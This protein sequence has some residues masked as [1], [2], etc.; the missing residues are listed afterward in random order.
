MNNTFI[1]FNNS[2]LSPINEDF[3]TYTEVDTLGIITINSSHVE[4]NGNMRGTS[5]QYVYK[6]HESKGSYVYEWD[7]CIDSVQ[8]SSAFY[9]ETTL[10]LTNITN[11]WKYIF[12]N[13]GDGIFVITSSLSSSTGFYY[14][15]IDTHAGVN[16]FNTTTQ[17]A[18][19]IDTWYY[20][21]LEKDGLDITLS[22]YSDE[23]RTSLVESISITIGIGDDYT[24]DKVFIASNVG[25]A[26]NYNIHGYTRNLDIGNLGGGALEG[27]IYTKDLLSLV[28]DDVTALITNT[29]IEGSSEI[30]VEFSND[31]VTW[32]NQQKIVGDETIITGYDGFNLEK[33]EY[34]TLYLRF[35]FSRPSTDD[36]V[37]L[38]N[39]KVIY[40]SDIVGGL[41]GVWK[42]YY[43]HTIDIKV[44]VNQWGNL[45]SMWAI[46]GKTIKGNEEAV[47]PAMLTTGNFTIPNDVISGGL[48]IYGEYVGNPSHDIKYEVWNFDTEEWE[49]I[50]E[51]LT[52]VGWMWQNESI[53]LNGR[54][55]QAF[56]ATH[57]DVWVR[58]IHT[59]QGNILHTLEIDYIALIGFF[60]TTELSVNITQIVQQVNE[61]DGEW[62]TYRL[63]NISIITGTNVWG[64]LSSMWYVDGKTIY[65]NEEAETPAMLVHGNFTIPNNLISASLHVFGEY[66][67]NP[68]HDI[69]YQV[70]NFDLTEWEALGDPL[71]SG[72]GMHW[73]NRSISLDGQYRQEYNSTHDNVWIRLIHTNQGV[74]THSLEVDYVALHGLLPANRQ[75]WLGGL[76]ILVPVLIILAYV[77]R[78]K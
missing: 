19:N 59:S 63:D 23:A 78:R 17:N 46:D 66:I 11:D 47:S 40:E 76:F 61:V 43:L 16:V 3:T 42:E 77:L 71:V 28:T 37:R 39:Y 7:I 22:I 14:Y 20:L 29:L 52:S 34:S 60:D 64:N 57:D 55:R 62:V 56:N 53:S 25:F 1:G 33:L 72:A 18:L 54:Y 50:G 35:S 8:S 21:R 67:G 15:L 26:T 65:G 58:L 2:V 30:T 12:D 68:A 75:W 10:M 45:S 24:Y 38:D 9:R 31:N 5:N 69:K 48:Y 51:P 32:Y 36:D 4:F 73:Q 13:N 6:T 41:N 27:I 70:W 49:L 74:I 44:G